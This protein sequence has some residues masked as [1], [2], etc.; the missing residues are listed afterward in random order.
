MGRK[1]K[2]EKQSQRNKLNKRHIRS[3]TYIIEIFAE[4]KTKQ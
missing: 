2:K 4:K 1:I 3:L